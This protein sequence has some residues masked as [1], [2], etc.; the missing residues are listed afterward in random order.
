MLTRP[1]ARSIIDEAGS[2]ERLV[3]QLHLEVRDRL[4]DM[5]DSSP[6]GLSDTI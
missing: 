2:L 6:S 4:C 3:K 5:C 1:A